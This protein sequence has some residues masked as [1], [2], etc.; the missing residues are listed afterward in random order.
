MVLEFLR[1]GSDNFG[2]L[3]GMIRIEIA[4]RRAAPAIDFRQMPQQIR[5]AAARADKSVLDLIV[6]GLH[7]LDKWSNGGRRGASHLHHVAAGRI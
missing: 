1:V 2:A 6:G 3:R 5:S 4:N 7:F